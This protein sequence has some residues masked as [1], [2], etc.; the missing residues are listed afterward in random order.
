V[1][2]SDLVGLMRDN[3]QLLSTPLE[4][5][6]ARFRRHLHLPD[7]GALLAMLAT[8]AA[9]RLEGDPVWL[10]LVGPPGGGK[11]ELLGSLGGL[12]GVH[13]AA[14]L[15]E[16]ALLSGTPKKEREDSA[17]GGLLRVIG[18]SGI[19]VAKDLG[20]ILSM[21][22]DTRAALLAAL[23]EIYDGA[24]TRHVGTGGGLTLSWAGKVGLVAGCTP[25]IDRQ[26]GVMGAMGERF[27]LFRLPDVDSAT[28]ARRA[29]AH[30]GK[31]QTMRNELAAAVGDLYG[32]G[33]AD[34][35]PLEKDDR[36][37]LVSLATLV[38]RCRS[39]VE[40][41]SYSR[42]VELIPDAEAPTR[43]VVVLARLLAGLDAIGASRDT[44]WPVI[45][46][47]ALD[48]IPAIRRD[49]I[50]A[51]HATTQADT[52]ELATSIGYPTSTAKRAL[53]DLTAHGI[54]NCQP[55]GKGKAHSWTLTD[56]ARQN[57]T[58][59]TTQPEMSVLLSYTDT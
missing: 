30:A 35:Q 1:N 7:P 54:V 59:A 34:P 15:T 49:V 20:S 43:L 53:E 14:T 23:R 24:W 10:V 19:I 12:E 38:V 8:V 45:T 4:R 16:A 31:E 56:F 3:R 22:R 47:A 36:E 13:A 57:Y 55:G 37:R 58:A 26:H 32:A 17:K 9:N 51:L 6:V 33:L 44:A 2:E 39:S 21:N 28:Q 50:T 41:D 52:T 27:I 42:E 5:T 48:S 46:K 18:E 25:T 40:R 11:S 29:L